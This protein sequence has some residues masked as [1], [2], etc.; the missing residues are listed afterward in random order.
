MWRE[1]AHLSSRELLSKSSPKQT[2]SC[3]KV[4]NFS[5]T[6]QVEKEHGQGRWKVRGCRQSLRSTRLWSTGSRLPGQEHPVEGVGPALWVTWSGFSDLSSSIHSFNEE[7]SCRILKYI[8][9]AEELLSWWEPLS[10]TPSFSL[11]LPWNLGLEHG[12]RN[13]LLT[14]D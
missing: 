14:N 13:N 6:S 7:T 8:P 3:N 2:L 12:V 10:P 5:K 9:V 11:L 4:A 1:A